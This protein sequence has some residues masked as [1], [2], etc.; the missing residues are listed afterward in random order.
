MGPEYGDRL[1]ELARVLMY[2]AGTCRHFQ[3]PDFEDLWAPILSEIRETASSCLLCLV[4]STVVCKMLP[5]LAV[6]EDATVR[7]DITESQERGSLCIAANA[8]PT[9]KPFREEKLEVYSHVPTPVS[10]IP[11]K[12]RT[13]LAQRTDSDHAIAQIK[14]WMNDCVR[15]PGCPTKSS[16]MPRRVLKISQDGNK[17]RLH[18]TR[19]EAAPYLTLSHCWGST[20]PLQTTTANIGKHLYDIPVGTLPR[21]FLDAVTLTAR[22]GYQYL[23]IDSLCIIQDSPGDWDREAS[24][25]AA[26]YTHSILTIAASHAPSSASSLVSS[27]SSTA[28]EIASFTVHAHLATKHL[29]RLPNPTTFPLLTRGWVYQERLLSRR[30][31]HFGPDELAWECH[32][33]IQCQ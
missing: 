5:E 16:V 24:L 7:L 10:L 26:I 12:P 23:W 9:R 28:I 14:A 20:G 18:L 30:V 1:S 13:P 3:R 25:M 21:L 31:V 11:V 6:S 19:G 2:P 32:S 33:G 4:V 15:H 17:V 8:D 22:L 29:P 27:L